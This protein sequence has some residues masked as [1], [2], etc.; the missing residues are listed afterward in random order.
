MKLP[1]VEVRRSLTL[2]KST[3]PADNHS[4]TACTYDSYFAL[5]IN[6]PHIAFRF[7]FLRSIL[8]FFFSFPFLELVAFTSL[9]YLS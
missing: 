6:E 9:L 3:I 7:L 1:W 5:Y 2:E 8:V 4:Q